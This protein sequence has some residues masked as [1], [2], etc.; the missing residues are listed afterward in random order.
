[1]EWWSDIWLNE[2]FA[3]FL[4]YLAVDHVEKDWHVV[5]DVRA[6]LASSIFL[7]LALR[8]PFCIPN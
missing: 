3:K 5:G 1:M 2:G 4:Q 8:A 6:T 7:I